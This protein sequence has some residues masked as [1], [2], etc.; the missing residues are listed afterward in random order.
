MAAACSHSA[1]QAA[2]RLS[3]ICE[4]SSPQDQRMQSAC[5]ALVVICTIASC[6][7]ASTRLLQRSVE[8]TVAAGAAEPER[9]R[10]GLAAAGTPSAGW[11]RFL[12]PALLGGPWPCAAC[13]PLSHAASHSRSHHTEGQRELALQ[14]AFWHSLPG[15]P[16]RGLRA[17]QRCSES[18]PSLP[19]C[20]L[21][22]W[23]RVGWR[24]TLRV[25]LGRV[26]QLQPGCI[27]PQW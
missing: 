12:E 4:G 18:L 27:V 26:D 24:T 1:R 23:P 21:A 25:A 14:P 2:A 16:C 17:A 22:G 10:L 8:R 15:A 19:L 7:Q 9:W 11:L 6:S 13:T 20:W 3:A 5:S